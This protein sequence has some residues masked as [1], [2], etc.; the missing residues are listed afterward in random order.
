MNDAHFK[1]LDGFSLDENSPPMKMKRIKKPR[2]DNSN[3]R[4]KEYNFM[5]IK[6][7]Q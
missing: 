4:L 1:E 6:A 3:W 5:N 7:I 2:K